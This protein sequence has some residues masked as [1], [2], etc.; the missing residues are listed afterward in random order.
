MTSD[1]R[2][3]AQEVTLG[4]GDRVIVDGLRIDISPGVIT[5]VIGPNGCGKST[6]L[7]SLGRL[8]RPQQGRILVDGKAISSMKTKSRIRS[9]ADR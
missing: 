5:T 7:R 3:S 8:L 9:P 2:L 1:T 4:H 6:M